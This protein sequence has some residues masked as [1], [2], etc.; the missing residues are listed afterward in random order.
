MKN[1]RHLEYWVSQPVDVYLVIRQTDERT[2][3]QSIRWMNITRYLKDRQ[4][5]HSRQIAFDGEPLT[6]EA[7]WRLRDSFFPRRPLAR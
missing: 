3:D 1:D 2:G 4:D 6:M 7:V 5:R